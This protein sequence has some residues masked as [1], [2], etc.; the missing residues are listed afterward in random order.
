LRAYEGQ[1]PLRLIA[2]T[3]YGQDED[4]RRSMA[5]GFDE[6]LVKPVT[7]EALEKAFAS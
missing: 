3:G 2:L 1:A 6:H 5:A 4:R 7:P